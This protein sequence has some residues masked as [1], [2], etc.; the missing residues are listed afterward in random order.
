MTQ[1]LINVGLAPNDRSGDSWRDAMIKTNNNFTELYGQFGNNIYIVN[2]ESEFPNQ[3]NS[4]IYLDDLSLYQIGSPF[5]HSKSIV[6]LGGTLIGMGTA[7]TPELTYLGSGAQFI[8]NSNNIRISNISI[9]A[10]NGSIFSVSGTAPRS[11][12]L[13]IGDIFVLGAQS[14][15][16]I[17]NIQAAVFNNSSFFVDDGFT[18]SG[19]GSVVVAFSEIAFGNLLNGSIAID[20]G[21]LVTDEVELNNVIVSTDFGNNAGVVA[22]S[23]LANSGN[24]PTGNKATVNN[25]NFVGL[26]TPL[27]NITVDDIRW[28]FMNSRPVPNSSKAADTF[29]LNT[30]VVTISASGTFV[31]VGGSNWESDVATRFTASAAGVLTY[32][33]EEDANFLI[34]A[35]STIEKVGGG[36]D[37]I[38][39]RI[40]INGVTTGNSFIKTGSATDNNN[41]TSVTS[42]GIFTLSENDTVQ[43]YVAN[44]DS[45][46]NVIVDRSNL[47]IING[48]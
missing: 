42:Q 43:V 34:I 41:P 12:T 7:S 10:P 4:F 20:L 23:G 25:S 44:N 14:M 6:S 46:S 31:A 16:T 8:A 40:S 26:T 38:E 24:I 15:G 1:E 21:S 3:D 37:F 33:G 11:N 9:S 5:S 45:T 35:V 13:V 17:T 22:L 30:E 36:S 19:P 39:T 27:Q 32:I 29:L 18:F 28:E 47:T 48:F 2:A